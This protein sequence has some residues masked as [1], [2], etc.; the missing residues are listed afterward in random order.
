MLTFRLSPWF[1]ICTYLLY[2][3]LPGVWLIFKNQ[4]F[5]PT[6]C[7]IIRVE[8]ELTSS[9]YPLSPYIFHIVSLLPP[10]CFLLKPVC[11][12]CIQAKATPWA[13]LSSPIKQPPQPY[14]FL[15]VLFP[16]SLFPYIIPIHWANQF[17]FYPDD[18]T[19]SSPETLVF[20]H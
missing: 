11:Q 18:G 14:A 8:N 4:H 6:V 19:H 2:G 17:I 9:V 7:P 13:F 1:I 5:G 20:K 16:M 10:H 15:L 12:S 3:W